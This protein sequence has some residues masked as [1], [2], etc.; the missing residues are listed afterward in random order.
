MA[1]IVTSICSNVNVKALKKT[2]FKVIE[3]RCKIK[4]FKT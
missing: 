3:K 1:E 2:D 4:T